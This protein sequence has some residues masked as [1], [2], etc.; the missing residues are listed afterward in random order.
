M[1]IFALNLCLHFTW[2][3]A[4]SSSDIPLISYQDLMNDLF[5]GNLPDDRI[6]YVKGLGGEDFLKELIELQKNEV[7]RNQEIVIT[8]VF[9]QESACETFIQDFRDKF[10]NVDTAGGLVEN[11]KGEYLMIYHRKRWSLPKG[12]VEWREDPEQAALREVKEETGISELELVEQ[13][14]NTYHTF[15]KGRKWIFK[16]TKWYKMRSHSSEELIPQEEE[17]ISEIR[18]INPTNWAEVEPEAFPQIKHVMK[19]AFGM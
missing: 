6:F 1:K 3:H 8:F 15:K 7:W 17:H 13:M 9:A 16:T 18:W 2:K 12:H 5:R 14:D 11:E 10:S 19:K 4:L